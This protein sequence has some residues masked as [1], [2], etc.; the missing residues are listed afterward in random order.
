MDIPATGSYLWRY[1]PPGADPTAPLPVVLFLH[2]AGGAPENYQDYVR[3]AADAAKAVVVLPKSSGASW[4]LGADDLTVAL[5][6]R[7]V[8][9]ELPVD[10]HRVSIAGHSA[11]GAYA[12]LLAY[13]TVSK[14][15]AVFILS[16]PRY[17]VAAVADSA[18]RAPIRMYYGTTDPNFTG[19]AEAALKA[20]W[21]RLQIAWQEDVR[22]GFSHNVWPLQT[23]ID[24]FLFLVGKTYV[25]AP[26]SPPPPPPAP[27]CLPGPTTLCLLGGRFRAEVTWHDPQ[28]K[29]G[30]GQV[31]PCAAAADSSGLFWFFTPDNWEMMLKVIDGCALNQHFW[32]FSAATTNVG[33]DLMVTDTKTGQAARYTN[34]L[35]QTSPAITDTMA[36][37]TCP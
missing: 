35:G 2:G 6:L 1:L 36:F 22:V 5:S 23:M 14:Y 32:V 3:E 37:A 25:A 8:Q 10:D 34:P 9:Q 24:G 11:G 31:A 20:Q 28:G 27:A 26:P 30:P 17:D 7:L 15:S 13:T 16:A 29:S 33:Y 21:D 18:Y 12:Y 4:D 19:G